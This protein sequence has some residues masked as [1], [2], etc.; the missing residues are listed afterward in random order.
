MPSGWSF[1]G[2]S[3]IGSKYYIF[4]GQ[5]AG[6]I[7]DILYSYEFSTDS[8]TTVTT[9]EAR[10]KHAQAPYC[11][12]FVVF[13]GYSMMG[14]LDDTVYY[15]PS[16]GWQTLSFSESPSARMEMGVG[17]DDECMYIFGG[18]D[19]DVVSKELWS[20]CGCST[21]IWTNISQTNAEILETVKSPLIGVFNKRILLFGGNTNVFPSPD[22]DQFLEFDLFYKKWR[23]LKSAYSWTVPDPRYESNLLFYDNGILF[24]GGIDTTSLFREIW[25]ID[26]LPTVCPA[27]KYN[28]DGEDTCSKCAAGTFNPNIGMSFC[29]DCIA[30]TYSLEGASSCT[31]CSKGTYS[32]TVA[33]T[34]GSTCVNCPKGTYGILEGAATLVEGCEDCPI[35]TYQNVEGKTTCKNCPSGTTSLVTGA[36][37]IDVCGACPLGTYESGNTCNYCEAGTYQNETSQSSC[38]GCP[39]GYYCVLGSINPVACPAGTYGPSENATSLSNCLSCPDGE[40][41]T[42]SGQS[43][44]EVCPI[45]SYTGVAPSTSCTLCPQGTF[46]NTSRTVN[47]IDCVIGT[48][49]IGEGNDVCDSCSPGFYGTV[50]A[51]YSADNCVKCPLGTSQPDYA[52]PNISSC[53]NCSMGS[54]ANETGLA[55][56]YLCPAGYHLNFTG[57]SDPLDCIPCLPNTYA[58]SAGSSECLDCDAN[59]FSGPNSSSCIDCTA[60]SSRCSCDP[61]Y[62]WEES[63]GSCQYCL[64]GYYCGSGRMYECSD[65]PLQWSYGGSIH[66][67]NIRR[68]WLVFSNHSALPCFD[69]LYADQDTLSCLECPAGHA[70]RDGDIESCP[71]G[72]YGDG[73]MRHCLPCVPGTYTD[74]SEQAVCKDCPAGM[75]SDYGF[76]F[77]YYCLSP[78][79]YILNGKCSTCPNGQI[80]SDSDTCAVCPEG[81]TFIGGVVGCL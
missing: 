50:S 4:G 47:C 66:C 48:Y 26:Y 29:E 45:G 61:G 69:P 28:S 62:Y 57:S 21:P 52:A 44:C 63:S 23:D 30:G 33:A 6:A 7:N 78:L 16:T 77:C 38:V 27:A 31:K 18:F 59:F 67:N 54:F 74:T 10:S 55:E 51:S 65:E 60:D 3:I 46:A 8:W 49:A 20:L 13:G 22:T 73:E 75:T 53:V 14:L 71:A 35:A 17:Y 19:G 80:S 42:S 32:T 12:G 2:G 79:E 81:T 36:T 9:G 68:G 70:C 24:V 39:I 43:S 34:S 1:A 11:S 72:F 64:A 5:N 58:A 41:T 56:C 40:Y 76:S 25:K 37:T 15:N